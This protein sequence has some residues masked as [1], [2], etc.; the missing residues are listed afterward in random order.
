MATTFLSLLPAPTAWPEAAILTG[1]LAPSSL[2][3][4][5]Q[6]LHAY[7]TFCETPAQALQAT[8]LARWRT[9]LAQHTTLS[10]HTINRLLAAIKRLT[11]CK[12]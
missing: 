7:L 12:F 11:G 3:K 6:A 5:Q 2:V 10:P 8:S 4:Y 1:H 9:H